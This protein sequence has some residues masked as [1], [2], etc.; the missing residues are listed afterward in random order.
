MKKFDGKKL[1]MLGTS[2]SSVE[3]VKYAQSEGAYVIVTDYLPT[4]KSA[5]KQ[6]ADETAMISTMDIEALCAYA[7]D[8]KIDGVFCGVSEAILISVC[9]VAEKV[10][11][12]CYFTFE[13]WDVMS[14]KATFKELCKKYNVPTVPEYRVDYADSGMN[15]DLVEFPVVVK[16]VDSSGSRGISVCHDKESLGIG[17]KKA[18]SFSNSKQLLVEKYITDGEVVIYYTFQNGKPIFTA[19]CDRY[20][21]KEQSGL[22]QLPT[23][24]I[25]PSKYIDTYI[26]KFDKNIKE[27]IKGVNISNGVMFIQAFAN[28]EGNI[29]VYENGFRLNGAQEHY[30]VDSICGF[31][32]KKCMINYALLGKMSDDDIS[33]MADPKL[34]GKYACKLSPLIGKGTIK[35]IEGLDI[36]GKLPSVVKVAINRNIDDTVVD[37]DLGTLKQIAYRAFIVEDSIEELKKTIDYIQ[38]N[39]KYIDGSGN[40]MMLASYNTDNLLLDY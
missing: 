16:P 13:Q 34:H 4:E 29:C 24:Y 8:N 3:L 23:A 36:I 28:S 25:F 15:L 18:L 9:K 10:G 20:T 21:N 19:M 31:D 22:A 17:I 11:L 32:T 38:E 37:A 27:L 6:I 35:T 39:V 12:P 14:N 40:S 1:L 5:A 7:I 33:E 2:T 26:E 30:I